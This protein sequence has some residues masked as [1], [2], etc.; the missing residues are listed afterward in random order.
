MIIN[1]YCQSRGWLFD[2]LKAGFQALGAVVSDDPIP[3]ANA[4][5]CIRTRE[6]GKAPERAR[7]VVQ[8]H[9][10]DDHTPATFNGYGLVS[11]VHERQ[12]DLWQRAGYTGPSMVAPIGARSAV[13][14]SALPH[15]PTLGWFGR[16]VKGAK[17][18][19]LFAQAVDLA[20]RQTTCDV[21]MIGERLRHIA[22]L[23]KLEERPAGVD[24]YARIDALCVTSAS[25]MVPL[26]MYEA[27]AAGKAVISTPRELPA[28][29]E[30]FSMVR[31][32]DDAPQ[33]AALIVNAMRH[34]RT[35]EPCAPFLRE[36]WLDWQ[37]QCA[38]GL[39][40]QHSAVEAA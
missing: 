21:L 37:M 1:A 10:L 26:S 38:H 39:A 19:D 9:D 18:S 28:T 11:F 4:W 7:T 15:R 20:R 3:N 17:R 22:R 23:G 35:Y 31:F 27:A 30:R 34:R 40:V 6:A 12:A 5:I 36:D 13:K 33:L 32:A 24:D 25:P 14:A 8:V 29:G 2:D 16:E